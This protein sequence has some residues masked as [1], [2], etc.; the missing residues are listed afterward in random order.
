MAENSNPIRVGLIGYGF[1]GKTFH[2]PLIG[3]VPGLSLVAV[4]SRDPA[5]VLADLPQVEVVADPMGLATSGNID[6]VVIAAPNDTHVPLARAALGAHKHVV[7]DKPFTLNLA[8]ARELAALADRARRLLSVFQ[9]RRWDSDF[10]SIRQAVADGVIGSVAHFESHFDRFRPEVRARW[11]EGS[12]PG[13]GIW[14]DLGPHLVDQAIQLFGVPDR[15]LASLA[16]QRVG[17]LSDD[18]AHVVLEYGGRRVILHAGMLA[19]GGVPRFLVHGTRGSLMKRKPDPQEAQL[20]AG[21]KP[22][23]QGWGVDPDPMLLYDGGGSE[24]QIP[25]LTGDQSKFYAGIE[26]ALRAAAPN[27]VP[28]MQA[29]AVVAVIEAAVLAARSG[30][31][32]VPE[33][34]DA[35]RLA[36]R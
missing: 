36:S 13:S 18:W 25:S 5:K 15:V 1:A 27:P 17:A 24:R 14:F 21:M 2:A 16:L 29:I 10:L 30:K 35:E 26:A 8:D 28:P 6:L 20:L 3:A 22:H 34:T 7:V 9:N 19:A 23:H 11:R 4:C 33:L 31:A 32:T 12:G